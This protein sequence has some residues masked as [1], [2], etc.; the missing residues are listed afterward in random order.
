[1]KKLLIFMLV[2]G[3]ASLANATVFDVITK[4]VGDSGHAGTS[5][6]KLALGETI[7]I[8]VVLNHYSYPGWSSYDGYVTDAVDFDLHVSG[9]GTLS[10]PGIFDKGSNRIG[11]D[12]KVHADLADMWTQS[13]PLVVSNQIAQMTGGSMSYIRSTTSVQSLIWNLFITCTG[14]GSVS[15]DLTLRGPTPYWDYWKPAT[16]TPYGTQ[17]WATEGDLGDMT[18][19]GV[20]E[21]AT[22][23]LLGLGGLF[24]SRRRR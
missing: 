5:A 19:Y 21:P 8:Q 2:L 20:P 6:D 15:V 16:S 13:N 4:G 10:C 18:I 7:E 9:P 23:A 17:Q 24:L 12:L 14:D 22:I 3:M 11:D 1:M